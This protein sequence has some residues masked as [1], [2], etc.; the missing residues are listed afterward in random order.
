MREDQI[1]PSKG[2]TLKILKIED[3]QIS[4][5]VLSKFKVLTLIPHQKGFVGLSEGCRTCPLPK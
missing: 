4:D 1:W 2:E 5:K 3:L